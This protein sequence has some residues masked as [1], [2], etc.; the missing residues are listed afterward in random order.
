M[1]RILARR[2][3]SVAHRRNLSTIRE[4][5]VVGLSIPDDPRAMLKELYSKTLEAVKDLPEDA[6]Y[7]VNVE[8]ITNYRL[9]VVSENEDI[10]KIESSLN[11]GQ[12]QEIIEQAENEL[13]LIP[14]M[15]EWKPWDMPEGKKPAVIQ[16]LD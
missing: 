1:L 14:H 12:V 16:V 15:A 5:G 8:K 3:F 7:R 9:G 6:A 2:T 4:P 10:E 13:E 11:I